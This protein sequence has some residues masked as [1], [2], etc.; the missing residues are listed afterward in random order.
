MTTFYD[1]GPYYSYGSPDHVHF[2]G[3]QYPF[4]SN[5]PRSADVIYSIANTNG[6]SSPPAVELIG[7]YTD[8]WGGGDWWYVYPGTYDFFV[9]N[10]DHGY[11]P[12]EQAD[13]DTYLQWSVEN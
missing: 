13:G 2:Y 6:G 11:I 1:P 7:N 4:N 8:K 12:P 10:Y 5:A 3:H 9:N